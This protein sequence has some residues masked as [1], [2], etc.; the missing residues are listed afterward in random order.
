M[1]HG[2]LV[3]HVGAYAGHTPFTSQDIDLFLHQYTTDPTLGRQLK[4]RFLVEAHVDIYPKMTDRPHEWVQRELFEPLSW[5]AGVVDRTTSRE[6][7]ESQLLDRVFRGLR[8]KGKVDYF[9]RVYGRTDL[10]SPK[11]LLDKLGYTDTL[12]LAMLLEPGQMSVPWEVDKYSGLRKGEVTLRGT[13]HGKLWISRRSSQDRLAFR[14]S[15][16][17]TSMSQR[18]PNRSVSRLFPNSAKTKSNNAHCEPID[19]RAC[20]RATASQ[21]GWTS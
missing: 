13:R 21:S 15:T 14:T 1:F 3:Y 10:N 17:A 7:I 12:L 6:F 5:F 8:Q 19:T 11:A 9:N 4:S 20:F 2:P 18:L 16:A